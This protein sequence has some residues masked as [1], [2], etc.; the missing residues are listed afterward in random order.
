[1]CIGTPMQVIAVASGRAVCEGRGERCELDCGLIGTP[2]PGAW[3][4]SFRGA[5]MRLMT[6]QEAAQANG[7]LDA[8]AAVL[9][10]QPL[11]DEY[12]ADL[13]GREPELPPHLR[14]VAE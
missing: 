8:L 6:P 1:M 9:A 2:E 5:A 11:S 12:F 13:T 14:G 7:A 4:L 3:V 10:G